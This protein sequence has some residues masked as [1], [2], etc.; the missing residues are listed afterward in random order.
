MKNK[1]K[2]ILIA[3]V[4]LVLIL[5]LWTIIY[6]QDNTKKEPIDREGNC[7]SCCPNLKEGESCIDAC[8]SCK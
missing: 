5:G 8:C 4:L 2:Y 7:C 1:F 6:K 3:A